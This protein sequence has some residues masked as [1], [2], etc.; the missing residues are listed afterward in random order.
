MLSGDLLVLSTTCTDGGVG[1]CLLVQR[2]DRHHRFLADV[3]CLDE[4]G[5]KRRGVQPLHVESLLFA[6]YVQ[7]CDH[8][9]AVASL[10]CISLDF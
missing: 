1:N 9:H 6:S 3:Y 5:W 8:T 10:H 2:L 4:V 7:T